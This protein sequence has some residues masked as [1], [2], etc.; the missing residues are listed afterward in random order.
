MSG[1]FAKTRT[2]RAL[3]VVALL[4]VC[5]CLNRQA[6]FGQESATAA[7]DMGPAVVQHIAQDK[8]VLPASLAEAE[9]AAISGDP[10]ACQCPDCQARR[11]QA[12]VQKA[13]AA[14]YA[15][16]FYSNNFSYI[17][18]PAYNDWYP[19]DHFKQMSIGDCWMLDMGG[20]FR[21][22]YHNEQ[23]MFPF[24]LTGQD[25]DFLLL[26][27]RLFVNAKYSDWFRVYAEYLDADSDFGNSPPRNIEVNRSDM[28]NLFADAKLMDGP[29]DLWFR[30]GR[31]ELLYGS[32][33]LISPLDWANT[34]RTFQGF[35][36]YW[37]DDDWNIDFFATHPV[38]IDPIH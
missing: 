13:M 18:S 30:I 4:V 8:E 10:M 38:R 23:N 1:S 35:K 3:L 19:G 7:E 12:D 37:Q 20:Q 2:R 22:R 5:W 17:N 29:G 25:N 6:A 15:P 28:L 16:L 32:Q 33:R 14:A 34:R 9:V 36:L 21:A 26:R 24:G 11:A 27:T 31:Q